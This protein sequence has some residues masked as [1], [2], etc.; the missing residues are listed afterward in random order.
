MATAPMALP[1][2]VNTVLISSPATFNAGTVSLTS[3]VVHP[4]VTLW[5]GSDARK[6]LLAS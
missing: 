6:A 1:P 5:S 4:C 3:I 2:T